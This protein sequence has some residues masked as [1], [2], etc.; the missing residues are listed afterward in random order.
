M[1]KIINTLLLRIKYLIKRRKGTTLIDQQ[2]NFDK[3]LVFSL[4]K[5]G[6]W[7]TRQQFKYL[8]SVLNRQERLVLKILVGTIGV[9][10]IIF[11]INFYFVHLTI[12]PAVGGEYTE[13][14]VGS[15]RYLN[16]ILAS[17]ND[18]DLDISRLI[19][20]GLLKYDRQFQVQPDLAE[21]YE[22]NQNQKI[23]RF[24]LR[25]NIFWSDQKK[26]TADDIIFTFDLIKKIKNPLAPKFKGVEVGKIDDKTIEFKLEK[27]SAAFL[28]SLTVGIL[29]KHIWQNIPEDR[30]FSAEY[31]L[32]PIGSGPFK[33]KSLAKDENGAI[34][35]YILERNKLHQP[36]TFLKRII[37]KFY[38]DFT[39]AV[40][41]LKIKEIN[42][43]S[44]FPKELKEKLVEIKHVNNYSFNLPHLTAIFLNPENNNILSSRT[45]RNV[46]AYLTPKKE[47][48]K[49]VLKGEGEIIEGP[50]LPSSYAFNPQLKKYD[51]NPNL[52]EQILKN[53]GW[54]KNKE[55]IWE[56]DGNILEITVT[57]VNQPDLQKT[58]KIIQESW[59]INGIKT[60][61]EIIDREKI[62][63]EVINPRKYQAL[64][65]GLIT[66]VE[67]DQ[68]PFWHSSQIKGDGLNLANFKERRVDE[69]LE[70]TKTTFSRQAR[71]TFL[72]EFQEIIAE[73][74]PAIFLYAT[75]YSYLVDKKIKGINLEKIIQPSDRFIGIEE[76]YIKTKRG[77]K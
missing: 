19:F 67:E 23:Y 74:I 43:L 66:G 18:V 47:I 70:K 13:G 63:T 12:K 68:F 50:I 14:I 1:I 35:S 26:I 39:T 42:G 52:A 54:T 17:S 53:A 33:F 3:K 38:S 51:F 34:K 21:G 56:K 37:F 60:N 32:R 28:A 27:P 48:L 29:P 73:E 31:N 40:D 57:T 45:I 9:A 72:A 46:L 49:N 7:P 55:N 11:V 71:K 62:Q 4:I 25:D 20:S 59:Q 44:Y 30:F 22:I 15:P 61:L 69:L 10:L 24:F 41:A 75:N 16:P 65:Y 64:L 2:T 77:R 58:A 36:P 76:W 5:R 6:G 8:F